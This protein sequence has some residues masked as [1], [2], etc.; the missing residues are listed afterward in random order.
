MPIVTRMLVVKG[1]AILAEAWSLD[2]DSRGLREPLLH[3]T[4]RFYESRATG[5]QLRVFEDMSCRACG[6]TEDRACEGGCAWVIEDGAEDD[7]CTKCDPRGG[8]IRG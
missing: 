7:I 2:P 1:K 4:E 3:S 6:C 5:A 8:I